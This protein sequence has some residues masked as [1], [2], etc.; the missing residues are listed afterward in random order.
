MSIT[1]GILLLL[2]RVT[3]YSLVLPVVLPVSPAQAVWAYFSIVSFLMRE[4][5]NGSLGISTLKSL[6]T[7]YRSNA[8]RF[9]IF[10][11]FVWTHSGVKADCLQRQAQT[12][13]NRMRSEAGRRRMLRFI[14]IRKERE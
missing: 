3:L 14:F 11:Q 5:D 9:H 1:F 4:R 2:K 7:T 8:E 10:D 6:Q 13:K 12:Q